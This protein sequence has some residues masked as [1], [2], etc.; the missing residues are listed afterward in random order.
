VVGSQHKGLLARSKTFLTGRRS[1]STR[2]CTANKNGISALALLSSQ[3]SLAIYQKKNVGEINSV[4]PTSNKLLHFQR[5]THFQ[6]LKSMRFIREFLCFLCIHY[7]LICLAVN[8]N[9]ATRDNRRN[10]LIPQQTKV[11]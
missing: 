9:L 11:T 3:A 10:Q 6:L 1:F 5:D 8:Y 4:P 2:N 7:N